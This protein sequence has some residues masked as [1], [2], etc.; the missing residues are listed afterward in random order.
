MGSKKHLKIMAMVFSFLFV[1]EYA[2]AAFVL[3]GTRYVFPGDRKNMSFEI[4]NNSDS[5]YG[6]QVWIDNLSESKSEIYFVPSPPVFKIDAGK[7]QIVRLLNVND[8]LPGDRESLFLINA[9]ELPPKSEQADGSV[10]AIAMNTQVKLFYRPSAIADGR[11]DAES[12]LTI[13]KKGNEIWL[14]NPTPYYFA[15]TGIKVNGSEVSIPKD[16]VV[17]LVAFKP[18]SEVNT[19]I[20]SASGKVSVKAINDWGGVKEYEIL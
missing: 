19:G 8:K 9:Q 14:K 10:L 20:S 5:T 18:M 12:Q 6:G 17:D 16:K 2:S 4:S 7:K 15:I 1:S 11:S 13:V 3:N